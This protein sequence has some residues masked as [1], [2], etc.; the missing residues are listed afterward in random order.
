MSTLISYLI[1]AIFGG[2]IGVLIMCAVQINR[3]EVRE[4]DQAGAPEGAYRVPEVR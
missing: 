2:T 3:R 4:E 1:A